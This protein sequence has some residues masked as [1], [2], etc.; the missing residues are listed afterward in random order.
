MSTPTLLSLL[1]QTA[2]NPREAVRSLKA[3]ALTPEIAWLAFAA[4]LAVEIFF[5]HLLSTLAGPAEPAPG[6]SAPGRSGERNCPAYRPPRS[7]ACL[8]PAG[9]RSPPSRG[10]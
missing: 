5:I 8:P 9:G 1:E 10:P 2:R 3:M 6:A 7:R 4:V